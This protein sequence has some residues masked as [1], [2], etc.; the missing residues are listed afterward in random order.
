MKIFRANNYFLVIFFSL[1]FFSAMNA[2]DTRPLVI[3][4]DG[5]TCSGKT[6]LAW[7]LMDSFAEKQVNKWEYVGVDD[8]EDGDDCW[9]EEYLHR[10]TIKNIKDCVIK[11]NR[12]VLCDTVIDD[13]QWYKLF[14]EELKDYKVLYVFVHCPLQ[15][16]VERL[17]QRN[18]HA[19]SSGDLPNLRRIVDVMF[20]FGRMYSKADQNYGLGGFSYKIFKEIVEGISPSSISPQDW[21]QLGRRYEVFDV[22]KDEVFY[23]KLNIPHDLVVHNYPLM[24]EAQSEDLSHIQKIVNHRCVQE[25]LSR[26][27]F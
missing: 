9:D 10:A 27:G 26:L 1:S 3:V 12:F 6:S 20:A 8:V 16:L 19:R 24:Q 25:I 4:L 15:I 13:I 5:P 22:R 7:S 14:N 21:N 17:M 23:L 11:K 18:I 2:M